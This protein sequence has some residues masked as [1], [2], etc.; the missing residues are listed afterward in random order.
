VYLWFI[1]IITKLDAN[2][3]L[4]W[5]V[6]PGCI[7]EESFDR[8]CIFGNE[9]EMNYH[10]TKQLTSYV[11]E[12]A[13]QPEKEYFD[14]YQRPFVKRYVC[15]LTKSMVK[16]DGEMVSTFVVLMLDYIS[17]LQLPYHMDLSLFCHVC[18]YHSA[19]S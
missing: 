5:N 11:E 17:C 12:L 6:G 14:G 4:C 10:Q 1:Q 3:R 15:R 9:V 16:S 19:S 2:T 13:N 7:G 8:H 18:Y